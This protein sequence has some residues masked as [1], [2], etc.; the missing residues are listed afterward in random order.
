MNRCLASASAGS[1]P[2]LENSTD[3]G[4][5]LDGFSCHGRKLLGANDLLQRNVLRALTEHCGKLQLNHPSVTKPVAIFDV[6]LTQSSERV[7]QDMEIS[8]L[9]FDTS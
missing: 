2:S 4:T 3:E 5:I 7:F 6:M 8:K 1:L 9:P